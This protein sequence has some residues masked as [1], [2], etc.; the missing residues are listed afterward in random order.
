M[1]D[2]VPF[3]SL[4]AGS[5]STNYAPNVVVVSGPSGTVR[6]NSNIYIDGSGN[7]GIGTSTIVRSKL[8]VSGNINVTV[9]GTGIVFPDGTFQTTASSG[10]SITVTND[11]ATNASTYYPSLTNNVTSG[12]LSAL[13][14][15]STKLF[16]NPS[17]GTLTST[18]FAGNLEGGYVSGTVFNART[19]LIAA[20]VTSNGAV[21]GT[22][23]SGS[24]SLSGGSVSGTVFNARTSLIAPTITSNGAISGTALNVTSSQNAG[25]EAVNAL[26][27]NVYGLFGQN[28][29]VRSSNAATSSTTGALVVT[30]GVGIGG[31]LFAGTTNVTS[32]TGLIV[33]DSNNP[34]LSLGSDTAGAPNFAQ[35]NFAG[36][37]STAYA[38][39]QYNKNT[40]T[41]STYMANSG[42][43]VTFTTY[44]IGAVRDN[45]IRLKIENTQGDVQVL[46]TTAATSTSTGALQVSG[47][48]GIA[49]NAYV[50]GNIVVT[51]S[52]TGKT[53]PRITT[54]SS[55]TSPLAWNSDN[56]D[57]YNITALANAL[58]INADAGTPSDG[59]K[60]MFRILD[61]GTARALTWTTGTSKSFREIGA[62]LPTTTTAS[63]TTYV[64]CIYNASAARWDVIAVAQEA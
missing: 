53:L 2:K 31:S 20:T 60:F 5:Q 24:T 40:N 27:S 59:E 17:T 11:V 32:S 41:L 36:G 52:L 63:K 14:T 56:Y 15:S 39:M 64:G 3:T 21:S 28:V 43:T 47:G 51:G 18:T 6:V 34:M 62:T 25:T 22:T 37:S 45:A 1:A 8:A 4:I 54:V 19:S 49:G 50:G 58:T 26:T 33:Y 12:T 30:G 42:G 61:N 55:V 7:V 35:I 57:Q 10:S 44:I 29:T 9:S 23:V 13:V 16:Y 38:G 48:V 46:N